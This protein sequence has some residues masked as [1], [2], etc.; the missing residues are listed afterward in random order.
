MI[1]G[2][3][4][5]TFTA[6]HVVI[7]VVGLSAGAIVLYG[8]LTADPRPA[9]TAIFLI[10]TVLTTAT[11]FLFPING[12]TPA[13]VT[14]ILSTP[15]LLIALFALYG[16][17]VEGSWRWVYVVTAVASLYLNVVALIA[18]GFLKVPALH[19][20]APTGSEPAFLIAQSAGLIVFVALGVLAVMRFHPHLR[21]LALT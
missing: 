4:L 21:R 11:G 16:R 14:G 10:S 12:L 19:A 5:Q 17:R 18:Q 9:W 6:L 3:S 20:L 2:L 8:L 1:I 7:S 15:L 13:L